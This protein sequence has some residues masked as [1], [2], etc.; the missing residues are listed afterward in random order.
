MFKSL[1]H[2][3][4]LIALL[5]VAPMLARPA[6]A[7]TVMTSTV[8]LKQACETNPGNRVAITASTD[9]K[10]GVLRGVPLANFETVNSG[11]TIV[12][13]PSAKFKFDGVAINFLGALRIESATGNELEFDKSNVYAR[14]IALSLTGDGSAL[15]IKE[16]GV[17][18]L[19][20]DTVVSFGA[21]AKLEANGNSASYGRLL[22][23]SNVVRLTA[24][25]K[26]AASLSQG[27]FWG[28]NGVDINLTGDETVYK[29]SQFNTHAQPGA[30]SF[31]ASGAKSTFE[32]GRGSIYGYSGVSLTMIGAESQLIASDITAFNTYTG[33]G[34]RIAVGNNQSKGTIKM[35]QARFGGAGG[36]L[37]EA[38]IGGSDSLIEFTQG[39][40]IGM[41]ETGVTISTGAGGQ[42]IVKDS[43]LTP[44][45]A[46]VS[47]TGVGFC[48]AENNVIRASAQTLCR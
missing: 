34:V 42:T 38:G 9:I 31:R 18:A 3:V 12:L 7:Q 2:L 16:S 24:G 46:P 14:S 1:Q 44:V 29:F 13:G 28:V 47:I 15:F 8:Q 25:N 10:E 26:F 40:V 36:L 27:Y 48:L 5:V 20:G 30:V 4:A 19:A 21:N 35:N 17:N 41:A 23:A 32:F 45:T 37:I 39:S 11:C 43:S 6:Q 22:E 33:A